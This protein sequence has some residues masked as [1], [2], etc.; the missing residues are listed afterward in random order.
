MNKI[1]ILFGLI[2]NREKEKSRKNN[3]LYLFIQ[4]KK[5]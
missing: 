5:I 3:F 2:E 4:I 1:Y